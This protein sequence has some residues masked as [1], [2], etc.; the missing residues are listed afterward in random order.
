MV[1]A[2]PAN[3]PSHPDKVYKHDGWQGYG[4]WLGTGN[5]GVEKDHK[6][7]PSKK[8]LLHAHP[9]QSENQ[10]RVGGLPTY[11]PAHTTSTS[12][13]GGK[14]TGTG[15][16][17]AG[18]TMITMTIQRQGTFSLLDT[19]QFIFDAYATGYLH[20]RLVVRVRQWWLEYS[21]GA[22]GCRTAPIHWAH[23]RKNFKCLLFLGGGLM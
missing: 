23:L 13:A 1:K 4:H 6:F 8:A 3:I 17:L 22:R 11:Q 7:L 5:V 15:W 14:G 21:I 20:V 19:T 12:M 10:E 16:A 9:H 2:R 18:H